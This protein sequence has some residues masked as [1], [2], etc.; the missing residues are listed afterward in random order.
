MAWLL[1]LPIALAATGLYGLLR[2]PPGAERSRARSEAMDD[3][4]IPVLGTDAVQPLATVHAVRASV[5][6]EPSA[7]R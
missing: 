4:S 3:A 2:M 7:G 6:A 5:E 1:L